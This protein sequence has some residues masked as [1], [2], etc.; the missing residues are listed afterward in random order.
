[1]T[2]RLNLWPLQVDDLFG[3]RVA[4]TILAR[5]HVRL[6]TEAG[7]MIASDPIKISIQR[8]CKWGSSTYDSLCWLLEVGMDDQSLFPGFARSGDR[9]G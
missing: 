3:T 5:G 8:P 1:M 2:L 6:H 7:H 9:S 4:E